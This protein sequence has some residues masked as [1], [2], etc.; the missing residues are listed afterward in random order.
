MKRLQSTPNVCSALSNNLAERGAF[1]REH[2]G[3][4]PTRADGRH[5]G[6][7]LQRAQAWNPVALHRPALGG[8]GGVSV[9]GGGA[10]GRIRAKWPDGG[11]PRRRTCRDSLAQE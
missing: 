1:N 11:A 2:I 6:D 5:G 9:L 7:A 4:K 10:Y 3:P 8:L